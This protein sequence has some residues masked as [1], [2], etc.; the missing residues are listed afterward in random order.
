MQRFALTLVQGARG[1]GKSTLLDAAL[2]RSRHR[3]V[4]RLAVSRTA[5]LGGELARLAGEP[6]EHIVA[7]LGGNATPRV[8]ADAVFELSP[9]R[10]AR[11]IVADPVRWVTAID[12]TRSLSDLTSEAT[13]DDDSLGEPPRLA[14]VL[15]EQAEASDVLGGPSRASA[16]GRSDR[17]CGLRARARAAASIER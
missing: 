4:V 11:R 1:S 13:I 17:A 14:V 8:L 10:S 16:R 5:D 6:I 9:R 7:E 2:E 12:G 3:G 15:A